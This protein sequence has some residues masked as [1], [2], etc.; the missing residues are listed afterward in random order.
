[1]FTFGEPGTGKTALFDAAFGTDMVT[2]LG[3]ED[4]EV[5]DF[6]GGYVMRGG[7][8]VWTDGALV[9][10][11]E[12]GVPLFVDEIGVIVPEGADHG[13]FSVMDGRDEIRITGQPRPGHRQGAAWLLRAAAPRTRTLPASGSARRC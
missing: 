13:L 4:T 3:T 7:S 1:M 10:A 2:M 12:R 5:A 8:Y 6:I 9:E 11:M